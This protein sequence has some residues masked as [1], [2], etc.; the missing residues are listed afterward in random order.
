MKASIRVHRLDKHYVMT[1]AKQG[2]ISLL[3]ALRHGKRETVSRKIEALS[4]VSFEIREGERVGVIG[5]NGAGKTTLLSILAG[6]AEQTSGAV[7]IEGEVHAMLTIG[8]V[9]RDQATGRENIYLDGAV[10]GKSREEIERRA[11]DIIDFAEIGEFIDRPVH[12]YSSGMKGRLS[13]AMGAFIEPDILILD[14]TLAAGDVFYAEKA[15]RRMK[16]IAS[17]GRIVLMVS[18]SLETIVEMCDRCLWLDQGR[19]IMDG[20]PRQVA[21]AYKTEVSQ[22]DEAELQRKFEAGRPFDPRPDA[23]VLRALSLYQGSEPRAA[24]A[25]AFEPLTVRVGASL[26]RCQGQPDLLIAI[27]RVDG[28]MIWRGSASTAL[29]LAPPVEGSLDISI[30]FD[31]FLLGADLYSLEATLIDAAG[32]I[33]RRRR[34]FEVVDEEGQFGG[35]P[36]LFLPP[37]I[38]SR[39]IPETA[40]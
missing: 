21:D 34:A 10:H 22:A 37:L 38:S 23:G 20:P 32:V 16:D 12:T 36:L 14:E 18:H 11:Q 33:D 17:K 4:D 31:P 27:T 40:P 25:R 24:T 19:L 7:E 39:P 28:R 2:S 9:L 30:A 6:V 3:Q 29:G 13:F 35:K 26:S 5:R 8:A 15:I 1:E